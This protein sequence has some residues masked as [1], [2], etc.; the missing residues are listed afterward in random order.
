MEAWENN[1]SFSKEL[2][3]LQ[4]AWDSTSLGLF[5]EC[6]RKYYYSVVQGWTGKVDN[7][8]LKFGQLYH[9]ALE[10][11]DHRKAEGA[12]HEEAAYAAIRYCGE[13]TWANGRPWNS[14]D[15]NKNRFTLTRT[16]A[17]YLHHFA[18][19]PLETV[20]LANGKPAVEVSFRM[21]TGFTFI[22]EE[23]A[24]LCGHLDRI[25]KLGDDPYILDRKTTKTTIDSSF[26]EKFNPD[27][28]MTTY[29]LA[30]TVVLGTMVKGIIIDGAQVA[31]NFSR[32]KRGT[33]TRHPAELE[34]WLREFK[35]Y[36]KMAEHYAE[37]NFWPKNDKSCGNYGGCP[38]R[39]ICS[40]APGMRQEWLSNTYHKRVWDPLQVR[41]DI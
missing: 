25:V 6:P 28:Q 15:S 39:A 2:P 13:A 22:T 30:S 11:Y 24:L 8:H 34:E 9:A 37:T 7:V 33:T 23:D 12:S 16:V 17:W 19:D 32:F 20:I 41:G 3:Q 1:S 21:D 4:I 40:K 14:D 10:L 5:K 35:G 26:F 38:F 27:N 31:V 36:L 18:E 29:T